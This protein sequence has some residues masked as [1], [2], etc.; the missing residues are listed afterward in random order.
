M[1]LEAMDGDFAV[2]L[3]GQAPRGLKLPDGPVESPE[4][5]GMLRDLANTIRPAFA[6]ASWMIV[7]NGEVVG[8]CSLVKAPADGGIDIGY[9]IV[10]SRRRLGFA[11]A[12]VASV[13]DWARRD[14]RV[15]TVRAE[16]SVNNLPSQ[17][18]LDCNGFQQTGTRFDEEDGDVI[19]WAV[20]TAQ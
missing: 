14:E 10:E 4:V 17:R 20:S 18:T 15:V 2:L 1:L 9:G 7:E 3:D 19:C 16:T 13:L 5:L 6:P 12:A 8:L 11:A